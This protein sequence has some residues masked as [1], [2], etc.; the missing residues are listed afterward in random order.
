MIKREDLA[1]KNQQE[2]QEMLEAD[3]QVFANDIALLTEDE[4][5]TKEEELIACM[6]ENDDYLKTVSYKI[7]EECEFD[8]S[9]YTSE[10][11]SKQVAEMIEN[12]EVEW[13]YTLGLYELSKFWRNKPT[14]TSYHTY[15][16][17]VRILGG[18]KYKGRDQWRK[19]LIINQFLSHCHDEYVRDTAYMIYLS[20]LHNI[21]IDALK[22]FNPNIMEDEAPDPVAE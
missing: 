11:V 5:I 1:G 4:V 3:M 8:G 21:V 10:N 14:T 7:S 19:I 13:S 16:S 12:N 6:N 20:N 22:K 18:M 17:T 2:L 9:I 15:D